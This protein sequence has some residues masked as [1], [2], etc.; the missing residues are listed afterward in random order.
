VLI[1]LPPSETKADGGGGP[2]LDL[3]RLSYPQLTPVRRKLVDAVTELAADEAA[4]LAVLKL[5]ERQ[6]DEVQRNRRLWQSPTMPALARYTGV[7]Y[8]ALDLRGLRRSQRDRATSRLAVASAL[9][10]LVRGADPI[11]AYRLSGG[12]VV[13]SVGALPRLWRPVLEPVLAGADELVLD[14]RSG[15]YAALA[16]LPHAI[17]VTVVDAER[18]IAISHFNKAYKGRLA[19][20]LAT[21]PREPTGIRPVIRTAEKAGLRLEQVADRTLHLV[22]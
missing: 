4:S 10:G 19:R 21:V 2:P 15:P 9:F 16:R 14:L 8:D 3:D 12:T 20:V 18:R 13:P 22:V 7:L 17:A 5:S 1:L 11:P 6:T